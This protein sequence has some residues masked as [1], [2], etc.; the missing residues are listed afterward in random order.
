MKSNPKG[1][2]MAKKKSPQ[3]V[4]E[5]HDVRWTDV[6]QA[7]TAIGTLLITMIGFGFIY[8]QLEQTQHLLNSSTHAAIY[9]QTQVLDQLM[10]EKPFLRKYIYE[11]CEPPENLEQRRMVLSTTDMFAD[12][13]EHVAQQRTNM[14]DNIWRPWLTY[15][16]DVYKSSPAYREQFKDR[17]IWYEEEYK[18]LVTENNTPNATVK[19]APDEVPGVNK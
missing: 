2:L 16:R 3:F 19:C 11:N 12:F 7:M 14:P 17:G 6:V 18:K 8:V 13:F 9:G 15:I 10:I 1:A 4:K 5:P